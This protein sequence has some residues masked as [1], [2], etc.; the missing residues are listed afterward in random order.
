MNSSSGIMVFKIEIALI[1]L[2]QTS[3]LVKWNAKYDNNGSV[4]AITQILRT[5]FYDSKTNTY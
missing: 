3:L 5:S 1:V 4:S 2:S